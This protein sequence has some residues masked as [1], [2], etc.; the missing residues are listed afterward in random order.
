[1]ESLAEREYGLQMQAALLRT[2]A[3]VLRS[4]SEDSGT[5]AET[6][7]AELD[8]VEQQIA[9]LLGAG[10]PMLDL[11]R[12]L[13]WT[14]YEVDFVWVTV[15]LASDPRLLVHARVLDPTAAQGVSPALYS[16][17]AQV[18]AATANM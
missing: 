6:V 8:E 10:R 18:D 2:I 15:A 13:G 16:R 4:G 3:A 9:S 5:T 11:A 14:W 1:M 17:I 12:R 7:R